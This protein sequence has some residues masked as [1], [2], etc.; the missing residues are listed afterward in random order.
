[1]GSKTQ[2]NQFQRKVYKKLDS[3]P[4]SQ[5]IPPLSH[6]HS[7]KK[8]IPSRATR[9]LREEFKKMFLPLLI[10]S[11]E[12][13]QM[14]DNHKSEKESSSALLG[15]PIAKSPQEILQRLEQMQSDILEAQR[16]CDGV[17]L[18]IAKGI[19]EAKEALILL[20]EE[21]QEEEKPNLLKRLL[22]IGRK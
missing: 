5:T 10:D 19:Q 16:W 18:Q 9:G 2:Y 3:S 13:R 4:L 22:K 1:M 12:L 17:I 21:K 6:S 14:I 20:E 11:F 8:I 15:N 7:E